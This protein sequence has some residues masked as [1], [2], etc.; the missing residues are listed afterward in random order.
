MGNIIRKL[1]NRLRRY[2]LHN[3]EN[4]LDKVLMLQG[5]KMA[6][7]VGDLKEI[8][9]FRE[10]EFK[11]YSQWGEDGILAWLIRMLPISSPRFVEFGVENYQESNTRFLLKNLNWKG[12]VLDSDAEHIQH[13]KDDE[14]YW[15]HDLIACQAFINKDNINDLLKKNGFTGK[16]GLLSIDIDG[17][18]YWVWE[19][20]NCIEP[21]IVVCEYNA[22]FGDL[23][24]IT[25]PYQEDFNRTKAH[26]S[27]LYFGAG[28]K[29]LERLANQK[30]YMLVGSN[31]AG[32]NAFF[33][34]Q[35]L[36][37]QIKSRIRQTETLPSLVRE[38]RDQ[39]YQLTFLGGLQKY[40]TIKHLPVQY[41]E[42]AEVVSLESLAPLYSSEWLAKMAV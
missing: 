15:R 35:N 7:R 38:S 25:V 28:I 1:L 36:Y 18:D 34:H 14:I 17:N 42:T 13:I 11:I 27:N 8:K 41:L 31:L 20:I 2:F 4:Q 23:H 26:Y 16:I 5:Q 29:A 6:L 40:E 32:S 22:V 37:L 10:V 30:Q 12:L 9:S 33:I 21:D 24:P 19:A 3:T 39:C